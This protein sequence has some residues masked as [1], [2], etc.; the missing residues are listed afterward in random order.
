MA[1]DE[2]TQSSALEGDAP[3]KAPTNEVPAND[4]LANDV[5]VNDAPAGDDAVVDA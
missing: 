4:G 2:A 1:I 3:K 5:P